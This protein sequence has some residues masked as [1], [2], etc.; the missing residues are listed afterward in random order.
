M[1]GFTEDHRRAFEKHGTER[2]NIAYDR[3]EA[4]AKAVAALAEELMQMGIECFR[5][6]FP[7]GMDANEYARKVT[8][9]A[10]S[11]GVLLN[12]AQW[13][14]KGERPESRVL[15]PAIVAEPVIEPEPELEPAVIEAAVKEEINEED[16]PEPITEEFSE[17]VPSL[18]AGPEP[19][20]P[21]EP[22]EMA[23]SPARPVID[24]PVEIRGQDIFLQ[25]GTRRYRIRGLN[26]NL[27]YELL[28]VDVLVRARR[29][30]ASRPS[31]WTRW[32]FT[33][34]GSAAA[35]RSRRR[36]SLASRKT[37]CAATWAGY[38]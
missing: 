2:V 36:R 11:L 4:G 28:K 14:G 23:V 31:T 15:G 10:K 12:K 18:A 33:L 34:R 22:E 3:D 32:T 16:L 5:V 30:A 6:L 17:N 27:S 37:Y 29:R 19:D 9:A 21:M 20:V 24:V 13:L 25:Q 7:K 1:N 38:C 26:K 8:P 35:S